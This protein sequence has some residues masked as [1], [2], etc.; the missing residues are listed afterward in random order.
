MNTNN[1][2][3]K[4]AAGEKSYG[5]GFQFPCLQIVEMVGLL[6]FDYIFIDGEHG[7]FTLTDI[8]QMS[9]VAEPWGLTVWARVPNIHPST[10]LRFLDRGVMGITGPH[11]CSRADAEMLVKA[12]KFAPQ[13]VR[14]YVGH[15]VKA[16]GIPDDLD[17]PALMAQ[18]NEEVLVMA[19]IEDAQALQNL[20]EILKV[21]GLD[22]VGFGPSDLSQSLG[23]PGQPDHPEVVQAIAEAREQIRAWGKAFAPDVMVHASVV[24]WIAQ[25]GRDF[26]RTMR[27]K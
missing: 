24:Q 5:C 23:H 9:M 3:A 4:M 11:I 1:I 17:I 15:R 2:K 8:E 22:V 6:G 27:G 12:C 10:I 14:S 25:G 7:T 18:A 21:D 20:P 19:L 16:Y 26:L 13:G